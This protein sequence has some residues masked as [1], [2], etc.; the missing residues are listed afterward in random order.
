MERLVAAELAKKRHI[1]RTD[2]GRA[3]DAGCRKFLSG[4]VGDSY[5]APLPEVSVLGIPVSEDR[6]FE[7]MK[8]E[9]QGLNAYLM[10]FG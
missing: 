5:Q 9:M 3:E 4:Q 6:V 2:D 10:Q 1:A 7:G 8:A